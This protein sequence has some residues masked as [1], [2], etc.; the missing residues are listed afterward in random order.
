MPSHFESVRQGEVLGYKL[1][2][3][4]W[5]EPNLFVYFYFVD[6]LLIDTGQSK[7]RKE[8]LAFTQE[9]PISHIAITHHHEDHT[10][11][12]GPVVD[13][14]K[15]PAFG[16][17]RTCE[18]LKKP[19]PISLAQQIV[20]GKQSAFTQL[21]PIGNRI[22]TERF[23]F[24]IIPIPG[25]AEDMVALYEPA[26]G[27][28]F[29]ADLYVNSYIAFFL[30]NES[31]AQQIASIQR[32]LKLDF[33]TLFCSHNPQ[34]TDGRDKLVKKLHFLQKFYEQVATYHQQ[35]YPPSQIMKRMGL[36]EKWSTRILSHGYLSRLNM[37]KSVVRDEDSKKHKP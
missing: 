28:L 8:V 25:H 12:L 5:G 35:G 15:C 18:M 24:D 17:Q 3:S 36:K 32:V 33:D 20:W 6:G 21:T 23:K 29:S 31:M 9:L 7:M 4:P 27:W 10:G 22:E 34:L 30:H 1:G 26:Q 14:I 16:S 11:N 13:S 37:V 19:P 2:Y